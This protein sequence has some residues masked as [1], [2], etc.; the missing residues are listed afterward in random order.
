MKLAMFALPV[1]VLF[2][3]P[4]SA[5]YFNC[6]SDTLRTE[7]KFLRDAGCRSGYSII[8]GNNGRCL[9]SDSINFLEERSAKLNNR[10]EVCIKEYEGMVGGSYVAG[11]EMLGHDLESGIIYE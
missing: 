5:I 4:A 11:V 10:Y 7:A 8:Y 6:A 2:S 9:T 3:S 1:L